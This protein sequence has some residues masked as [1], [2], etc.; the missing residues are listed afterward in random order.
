MRHKKFLSFSIFFVVSFL[1]FITPIL[2]I[3]NENDINFSWITTTIYNEQNPNGFE[4]D[5]SLS[6]TIYNDT[7]YYEHVND[8]ES[9]NYTESK[10]L[11]NKTYF[12]DWTL[13]VAPNYVYSWAGIVYFQDT[14]YLFENYYENI[15]VNCSI[16]DK[17]LN[18][19]QTVDC[20]EINDIINYII[21][22]TTDNNY[23]YILGSDG[24]DYYILKY[25]YNLHYINTIW[26]DDLIDYYYE[27]ITYANNSIYIA[28]RTKAGSISYVIQIDFDGNEIQEYNIDSIVDSLINMVFY[29]GYFYCFDFNYPNIDVYIFDINF[30]LI[31]NIN[32]VLYSRIYYIANNIVFRCGYLDFSLLNLNFEYQSYYDIVDY[33][34]EN[35]GLFDAVDNVNVSLQEQTNPLG[36]YEGLYDFDDLSFLTNSCTGNCYAIID[37]FNQHKDVLHLIDNDNVAR[38]SFYFD[39]NEFVSETIEFYIASNDTT[40]ITD[41]SIYSEANLEILK[42]RIYND[43]INIID[44]TGNN[45]ILSINDDTWYHVKLNINC[46]S[47]NFTVY[48]DGVSYGNFILKNNPNT[49]VRYFFTTY[50]VLYDYDSYFDSLGFYF[51]NTGLY[52]AS[53]NFDNMNGFDI[54]DNSENA[55]YELLDY[56]EGHIN[57]LNISDYGSSELF[58]MNVEIDDIDND[59]IELWF[60][61]Q[62]YGNNYLYIQLYDDTTHVPFYLKFTTTALNIY[63]NDGFS[64]IYFPIVLMQWYLL[65]IQYDC[66]LEMAYIYIDNNLIY[67]SSNWYYSSIYMDYLRIQT[68]LAHDN[69][70]TL[71]DGLGFI[72]F[73]NY[74]LGMNNN[75]TYQYNSYEINQNL[76]YGVE[77]NGFWNEINIM[78]ENFTE[79]ISIEC[80][81]GTYYI[82]DTTTNF[83]VFFNFSQYVYDTWI[84]NIEINQNLENGTL[85]VYNESNSLLF[86]QNFDT[87][88]SGNIKYVKYIQYY[89]DTNHFI[90][91]LNFSIES[92]NTKITGNN[93][94][95]S[96][97][98]DLIDTTILDTSVSNLL[99]LDFYGK[100][101]FYLANDT[102]G[103]N[104]IDMYQ[105]SN[106]ISSRNQ[107]ITLDLINYNLL[108]QNPY[109]IIETLNGIYLLNSILINGSSSEWILYDD[110]GYSYEGSFTSSNINLEDSYFYIQ[111]NRLYFTINYNDTDLEYMKLTFNIQDIDNTNYQLLYA[112]YMNDTNTN[113]LN[114]FNLKQNDATYTKITMK[115][116]YDSDIEILE[117]EKT[118]T[119]LEF[120]ISDNDLQSNQTIYGYFEDFTFNYT[121][122]IT[123][124]LFIETILLILVPLMIILAMTIT[125]SHTLKS[126]TDNEP[127]NKKVFFPVF[128][129]TSIIVFI[130]GF[131]ETWI[132]FSIIL[133]AIVYIINKRED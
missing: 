37:D 84:L 9:K 110:R 24:I 95:I 82:N 104:D 19:I 36:Y 18:Y 99:T 8:F 13:Y 53:F 76:Q 69:I 60:N 96:Y 122:Q 59:T 44:D 130:L 68:N 128:L 39:L 61:Q 48:I 49:I 81:N 72:S 88:C 47:N 42:F 10:Y 100:Y 111:D 132:L 85:Y 11:E 120:Y 73:E 113:Y 131:F 124:Q 67:T 109:L 112:T 91:L 58:G 117:Q 20:S 46:A 71:F 50:N 66:S 102:Y 80:V 57:V 34:P 40:S 63:D 90:Y 27:D 126:R 127:L 31:N 133:S 103:N 93:G 14:Y 33:Y 38:C 94:F 43:Y 74:T 119:Y 3:T 21:S 4:V 101:R 32:S 17:Q 129:I 23:I 41:F 55:T 6:H 2:A 75:D 115:S 89:Q 79:I 52:N 15:R 116:Y 118:T 28:S 98:L 22:I 51:N 125:I 121:D 62:N 106:W 86:S 30:N 105:I 54:T 97:E 70:E 83:N 26:T 29:E 78:N 87:N 108:I 56:Y 123:I 25:D 45:N 65:K 107:E 77:Y 114:Q 1:F 16:V 7:D 5:D 35:D 92:N 12:D 64:A